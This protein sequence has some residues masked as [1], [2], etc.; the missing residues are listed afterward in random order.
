MADAMEIERKVKAMAQADG[1]FLQLPEDT[2]NDTDS[3][4]EKIKEK[5]DFDHEHV[6]N[7]SEEGKKKKRKLTDGKKCHKLSFLL[8]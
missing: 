7:E 4:N 5:E 6:S 3:D 8:W 2:P 1:C